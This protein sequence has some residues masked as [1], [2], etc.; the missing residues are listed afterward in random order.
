[1]R[2]GIIAL[3]V[4][5]F[6][7]SPG[8]I[9]AAQELPSATLGARVR[10]WI[11]QLTDQKLIGTLL[12]VRGDTLLVQTQGRA[13]TTRIPRTAVTR[14]DISVGQKVARRDGCSGRLLHRSGRRRAIGGAGRERPEL[15]R[16]VWRS[17][18]ALL[19]RHWGWQW[20]SHRGN[21]WGVDHLRSLARSDVG[22]FSCGHPAATKPADGPRSL[23]QLLTDGALALDAAAAWQHLG[24]S[25]QFATFF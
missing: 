23:R 15:R 19:R 17:R 2:I 5:V 16:R 11:P 25:C 22:S 21:R 6:V 7:S 8:S 4:A 14:L 24:A 10:V 12:D 20:P 3:C 13:D 9:V 1:M 18:C